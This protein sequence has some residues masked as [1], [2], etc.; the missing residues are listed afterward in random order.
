MGKGAGNIESWVYP[1]RKG[2]FIFQLSGVPK[3]VAK[4]ALI[5][6]GYKIP[7]KSKFMSFI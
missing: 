7:F 5:S 2:Q 6:A 3:N 4:N 1:V